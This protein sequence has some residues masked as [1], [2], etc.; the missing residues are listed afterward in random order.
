MPHNTIKMEEQIAKIEKDVAEIKVALIGNKEMGVSGLVQ[1]VKE[2][3][4][5]IENDKGF[6]RKALAVI[7][8][9][10][11]AIAAFFTLI[12]LKP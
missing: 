10:Q 4:E 2:N 1:E 8:G 11:I 6:K 7:A 9:I 5:Y 12:K 3:S